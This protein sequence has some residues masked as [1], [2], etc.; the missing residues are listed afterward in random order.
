MGFSSLHIHTWHFKPASLLTGS[1]S[2]FSPLILHYLARYFTLSH[3]II[4]R[5]ATP[6]Q[7]AKRSDILLLDAVSSAKFVHMMAY[8]RGRDFSFCH[9]CGTM[10]TVP[11]TKYAECPLCKTRRSIKRKT[12][13][14]LFFKS[15]HISVFLC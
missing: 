5:I 1:K 6:L 4:P 10:L 7:H 15:I 12:Y 11:S 8:S 2:S 13:F 9:L 3:D 14:L